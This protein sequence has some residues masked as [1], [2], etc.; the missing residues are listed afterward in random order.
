[1]KLSIKAFAALS[2]PSEVVVHSLD[3]SLYQ[4][5]VTVDGA[6]HLLVDETGRTIRHRSLQSVREM[7]QGFPVAAITLRHES[8][9]DEMVGQPGREQSNALEVTVCPLIGTLGTGH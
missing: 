8:A 7:L 6:R 1:M 9:Y 3:R 4:V 2:T 5:T